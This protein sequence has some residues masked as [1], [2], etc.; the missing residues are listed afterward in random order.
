MNGKKQLDDGVFD[1]QAHILYGLI[2][3]N[4]FGH[5]ISIN[6]IEG[7]LKYLCGRDGSLG[8][9]FE[10][11]K[12]LLKMYPGS[13]WWICLCC[14]GFLMGIRGL[15]GGLTSLA[16]EALGSWNTTM[17]KLLKCSAQ[18]NL[19]RWFLISDTAVDPML[20]SR[21][22]FAVEVWAI[23]FIEGWPPLHFFKLLLATLPKIRYGSHCQVERL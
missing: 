20:W 23:L 16:M 21:C 22:L 13:I 10:L 2:H 8:S 19:I 9:Y 11:G 3:S 12:S 14:M 18:L 15:A 6:G 5:L 1:D 7:G 17:K 4:G